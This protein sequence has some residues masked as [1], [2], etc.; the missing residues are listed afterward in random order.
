MDR[1]KAARASSIVR[2][3]DSFRCHAPEVFSNTSDFCSRSIRA[4]YDFTAFSITRF[5]EVRRRRAREPIRWM[6]D[7]FTR[8]DSILS[9]SFPL[10]SLS[11]LSVRGCNRKAKSPEASNSATRI[12]L[13][14]PLQGARACRDRSRCTPHPARR[15]RRRRGIRRGL[16]RG[17]VRIAPW[18]RAS[19]GR[20][21]RFRPARPRR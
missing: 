2:R 5:F 3:A 10:H 13:L 4:A 15:R 19:P 7:S 18:A 6:T 16:L 9:I 20:A 12:N 11:I 17:C 14:P 21:R 8:T 1:R